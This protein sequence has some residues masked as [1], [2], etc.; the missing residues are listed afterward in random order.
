MEFD[1]PSEKRTTGVPVANGQSE[2]RVRLTTLPALVYDQLIEHAVQYNE[3]CEPSSPESPKADRAAKVAYTVLRHSKGN[4]QLRLSTLADKL[5]IDIRTLREVFRKLYRVAPKTYQ[6]RI[7]THWACHALRSEPERKIESIAA[8]L[9]YRDIAD[10]NHLIHR[11]T[12]LSPREYQKLHHK[13]P[14]SADFDK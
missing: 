12:G 1:I 7:R 9:G 4:V 6:V 14:Q 10:F 13:T 2:H 5:G 3:A 8:D 11:H